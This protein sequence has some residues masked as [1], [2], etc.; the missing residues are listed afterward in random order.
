V[1][2]A[3]EFFTTANTERCWRMGREPATSV[4][5]ARSQFPSCFAL[6]LLPVQPRL[7]CDRWT[8]LIWAALAVKTWMVGWK[9]VSVHD[10]T[11]A[12]NATDSQGDMI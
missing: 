12:R 4:R 2:L 9:N 11:R 5:Y 1:H 7:V 6:A 10:Q 8:A 3:E